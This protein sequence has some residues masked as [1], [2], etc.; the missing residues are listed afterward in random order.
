[1]HAL[2]LALLL[3]LAAAPPKPTAAQARAYV[4][5][6]GAELEPLALR[7]NTANWVNLTYLTD[8]TDRL[9]AW[10]NEEMMAATTRAILGT[11]RFRGLALDRD[12]ARALQ[13]LR[14]SQVLP[15]PQQPARR[16]ELAAVAARLESAYGKAKYCGPDGKG[17]CRDLGQLEEVLAQSRSWDEL[18][19]AWTG[20]HGVAAPTRA[21]YRR[22]VELGND[23]ARQIGFGDM[24]E[25]WRSGYDMPPAAFEADADRIWAQVQPLYR[26]LHCLVRARLQALHGKERVPD[27]KPIPAHLLG[28]MWAQQWDNLYPLLVP[29]PEVAPHDVD[30]A[31]REQGWSA[32]RM[33]R[34]GEAFFT[35]LGLPALPATFWERSMLVKPRDRE[36]VCHASAFDV[37]GRDDIRVKMCT[38]PTEDDLRTVHHELGHNYYQRAYQAQP[39]LFRSGANDGFHEAIGDALVLSMTPGYYARLGLAPAAPADE[40]AVVNH[41]LRVALDRVAFLPFGRLIDQWRWD[42]FSGKTPPERWNE[43]WWRLRREVQGV[44]APVARGEGAFD[45]GAKYHVPAHVPYTR[46]FLAHVYMFQFHRALCRAAGQ[47]GPLHQCSI[48]GSREAGQRLEALLR[49]GASR[50]WPEVLEAMTG[51]RQADASALLEYFAPLRGWLAEQNRGRTCGW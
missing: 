21:D 51:E 19:D 11:A 37:D 41:Q 34:T 13:L 49:A 25:L 43:A 3:P 9:A 48:Y 50:P 27:G 14:V 24:G 2:A 6:V 46:Y 23:G 47:G 44:D 38:R 7:Q 40:R 10:A 45:P 18:L 5:R 30:R 17:A 29:H 4:A 12:T 39:Y 31:L 35:S 32:E 28:N 8:D 42:V 16:A 36:V 1:M 33:V 22:L 26:E 15:A 20:W